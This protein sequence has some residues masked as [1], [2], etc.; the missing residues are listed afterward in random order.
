MRK[1]LRKKL[2]RRA[3]LLRFRELVLYV[4]S[5]HPEGI[6]EEMV[7]WILFRADFEAYRVR[8]RSISGLIWTKTA[9]G[10]RPAFPRFR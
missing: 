7:Y 8:G 1:R 5:Q 9:K 4:V 2:T 10:P 6:E 3:L